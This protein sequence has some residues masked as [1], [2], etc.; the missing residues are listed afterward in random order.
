MPRACDTSRR[1]VSHSE[2]LYSRSLE[3][4]LLFRFQRG[5]CCPAHQQ[6]SPLLRPRPFAET[7]RPRHPP[8]CSLSLLSRKAPARHSRRRTESPFAR[9]E[10][11]CC[12]AASRHPMQN[13]PCCRRNPSPPGGLRVPRVAVRS[14]TGDVAALAKMRLVRRGGKSYTLLR[15]FRGAGHVTLASITTRR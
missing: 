10:S 15:G 6:A 8:A 14:V 12:C 9:R 3:V 11:S 2:W 4:S 1:A 13:S 7:L 5:C